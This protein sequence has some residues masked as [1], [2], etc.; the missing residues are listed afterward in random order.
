MMGLQQKEFLFQSKWCH[1]TILVAK[2][3]KLFNLDSHLFLCAVCTVVEGNTIM[4]VKNKMWQTNFSYKTQQFRTLNAA[5]ILPLV[6]HRALSIQQWTVKLQC[7]NIVNMNI[8]SYYLYYLYSL[9][10]VVLYGAIILDDLTRF[11]EYK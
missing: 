7:T 4:I 11:Y 5:T 6:L 2:C 8:I 1:Q 3:G 9:Y 10:D